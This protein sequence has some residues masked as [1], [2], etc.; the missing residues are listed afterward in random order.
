MLNQLR[1][2]WRSHQV[3]SQTLVSA[4]MMNN[5]YALDYDYFYSQYYFL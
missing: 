3:A 2:A 5:K 1:S 4:D